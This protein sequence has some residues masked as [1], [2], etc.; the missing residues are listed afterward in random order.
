MFLSHVS[1]QAVSDALDRYG[2]AI[3]LSVRLACGSLGVRIPA[4]T[5]LSRKTDSD[6]STI[7]C[8]ATGLSVLGD[9]HYKRMRR[10]TVGV[11]RKTMAMT[12]EHRSKIVAL[13]R[14]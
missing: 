1:H 9:D 14:Q 10:V 4:A 3:R 13:H 12:T 6:N 2:G 8:S 7:K 5:V 11:A